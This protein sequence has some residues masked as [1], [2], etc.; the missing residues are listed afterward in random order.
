MCVFNRYGGRADVN[1]HL[2]SKKHKAAGEAAASSSRVTFFF[3]EIGSNTALVLSAKKGNF[4][5]SHC[6]SWAKF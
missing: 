5:L 3:N 2:D 4:C 6:Y 1:S